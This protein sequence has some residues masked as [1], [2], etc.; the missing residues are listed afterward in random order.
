MLLF[1]TINS[2]PACCLS[3]PEG[4]A[5]QKPRHFKNTRGSVKTLSPALPPRAFASCS[6]WLFFF[7]GLLHTQV[8]A[9][10]GSSD[11]ELHKRIK[12]HLRGA[13]KPTGG[14][15][16]GHSGGGLT[17]AGSRG[18]E[19]GNGIAAAEALIK[20]FSSHVD[21]ARLLR[22]IREYSDSLSISEK[23]APRNGD[24]VVTVNSSSIGLVVAGGGITHPTS[25]A[26]T[27]ASSAQGASKGLHDKEAVGKAGIGWSHPLGGTNGKEPRRRKT[28]EEVETDA[29]KQG[30]SGG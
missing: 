25:A 6:P 26:E 7:I 3:T 10:T 23:S 16:V 24:S 11:A 5:P 22:D 20:A 1:I 18:V 30:A 4:E 15:G 17:A 2:P 29:A 27:A 28:R 14:G 21:V 12:Q 19:D 9:Y 8:D 13:D